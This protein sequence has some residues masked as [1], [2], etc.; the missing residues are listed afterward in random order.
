[1]CVINNNACG[2]TFCLRISFSY[3]FFYSVTVVNLFSY[4][5]IFVTIRYAFHFEHIYLYI[6]VWNVQ[7]NLCKKKQPSVSQWMCSTDSECKF[8]LFGLFVFVIFACKHR[9]L[10]LFLSYLLWQN[11]NLVRTEFFHPQDSERVECVNIYHL[12]VVCHFQSKISPKI[13]I[14][15]RKYQKVKEWENKERMRTSLLVEQHAPEINACQLVSKSISHRKGF[16]S[17]FTISTVQVTY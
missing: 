8:S 3:Y 12:H 2:D 9:L 17:P 7:L 6:Y 5:V 14:A 4:S 13:I 11:T 10:L 15:K 1:M 16:L